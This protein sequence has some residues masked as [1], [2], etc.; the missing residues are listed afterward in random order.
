MSFT[1]TVQFKRLFL[2]CS[3]RR[4]S[5][6][7]RLRHILIHPESMNRHVS[8]YVDTEKCER[9]VEMSSYG[10]TQKRTYSKWGF[11]ITCS[12]MVLVEVS[13]FNRDLGFEYRSTRTTVFN[14][15]LQASH[16]QFACPFHP[17]S[18]ILYLKPTWR[19]IWLWKRH[20]FE[21]RNSRSYLI[22]Y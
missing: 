9:R 19:A 15:T 13:W 7:E 22:L 2:L 21:I 4:R 17:M 5:T 11:F 20:W 3:V 10:K 12:C 6:I 18:Y 1:I 16:K 14:S 8:G